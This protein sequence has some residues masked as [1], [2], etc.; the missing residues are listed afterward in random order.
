MLHVYTVARRAGLGPPPRVSPLPAIGRQGR[1][2]VRPVPAAAPP[3]RPPGIRCAARVPARARCRSGRTAVR[4]RQARQPSPA[5]ARCLC[6]RACR[7]ERLE[8]AAGR[9]A[10]PSRARCRP[11]RAHIFRRRSGAEHIALG[12]ADQVRSFPAE[13]TP[14][15][16]SHPARCSRIPAGSARR[17]AV[18]PRPRAGSH[19]K[20]EPRCPRQHAP[21]HRRQIV[22]QVAR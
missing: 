5:P 22:Q 14:P 9:V 6:R 4:F 15:S 13:R 10:R 21:Q 18:P 3:P 8:G 17:R 16:A 7:E 19:A 2:L 20:H 1:L 12:V 11:P